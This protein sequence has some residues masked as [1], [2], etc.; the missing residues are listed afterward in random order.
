MRRSLAFLPV[1]LL[2]FLSSLVLQGSCLHAQDSHIMGELK[3]EAATKAEKGAGVWVD[4]T[5]VGYVKELKGK[6]K[7]LLLPGRREIAVRQ[8]GYADFTQEVVVEPG[9]VQVVRIKMSSIPGARPP[10]I[11]AELKLTVQPERA[12]VFLDDNYIG[13]AGEMGGAFHSLLISPGKHRIKIGHVTSC[14]HPCRNGL[15]P[16]GSR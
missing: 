15:W 4:G 14:C 8:A 6:K 13:H 11:T 2:L 1:A 9:Q 16:A 10:A 5:Y 7:L 3:L 12:A